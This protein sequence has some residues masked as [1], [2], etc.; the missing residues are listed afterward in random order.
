MNTLPI[1]ET[2]LKNN[3]AVQLIDSFNRF[4]ALLNIC[5]G[6]DVLHVQCSELCAQTCSPSSAKPSCATCSYNIKAEILNS[7]YP[8]GYAPDQGFGGGMVIGSLALPLDL[9]LLLFILTFS[10]YFS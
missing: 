7:Q 3:L 6:P 10:V 1:A 2:Y 9:A 8:K 4:T 5:L